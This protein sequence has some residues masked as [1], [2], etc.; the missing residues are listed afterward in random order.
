VKASTFFSH[1]VADAFLKAGRADLAFRQLRELFEPMRTLGATT[2]WEAHRPSASLCHGFSATGLHQMTAGAFGIE[3]AE[4]GYRRLRIRPQ[5]LTDLG[6]VA[7]CYPLGDRTLTLR[8]DLVANGAIVS[9]YDPS[10]AMIEV[11]PTP[12]IVV[13]SIAPSKWHVSRA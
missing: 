3:A 10:S 7:V 8:H 6:N 11:S 2:L 1:F 9:V 12:E 13:R 4:P 5:P